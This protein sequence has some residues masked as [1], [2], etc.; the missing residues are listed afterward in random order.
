MS[1]GMIDRALL[2]TSYDRLYAS[3]I[4][5]IEVYA[6]QFD[7]PSEKRELDEVFDYLEVINVDRMIADLCIDYRKSNAKKIK[8]PD[9]VILATARSIEADLI[10]NNLK[11]FEKIDSSVNIINIE[12]FRI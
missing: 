2:E 10:T 4:T 3:I 7:D 5:Y 1:K 12:D 6:Y 9:A 11:D 8:L